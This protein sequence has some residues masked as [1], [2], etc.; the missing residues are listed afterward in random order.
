MENYEQIST[1]PAVAPANTE[2]KALGYSK[3]SI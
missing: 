2:R 3:K 1:A